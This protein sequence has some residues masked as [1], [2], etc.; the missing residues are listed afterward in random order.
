MVSLCLYRVNMQYSL[1]YRLNHSLPWF[2]IVS[3]HR[4]RANVLFRWSSAAFLLRQFLTDLALTPKYFCLISRLK[5]VLADVNKPA[6][7]TLFDFPAPWGSPNCL[8]LSWASSVQDE[9][10]KGL[11]PQ[12]LGQWS[13]TNPLVQFLGSNSGLVDW[14]RSGCFLFD[15][16]L[17]VSWIGLLGFFFY[18]V[19]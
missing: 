16:F 18:N 7:A 10:L 13:S 12:P 11:I 14:N 6:Q 5:S 17:S 3:K 15:I 2:S 4:C 1:R 8:F 19:F 9:L